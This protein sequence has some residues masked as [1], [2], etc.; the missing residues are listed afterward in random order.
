[1]NGASHAAN[2][3]QTPQQQ[4]GISVNSVT[5]RSPQAVRAAFESTG[6]VTKDEGSVPFPALVSDKLY[7]RGFDISPAYDPQAG[8]REHVLQTFALGRAGIG[9][10]FVFTGGHDLIERVLVSGQYGA[11]QV[12]QDL[13]FGSDF[14]CQPDHF[15]WL[16]VFQH[17]AVKPMPGVYA[18]LDSWFRHV[19]QGNAPRIDAAAVKTLES[20]RFGALS[21]CPLNEH[22]N[23]DSWRDLDRCHPDFTQVVKAAWASNRC[24][25]PNALRYKPAQGCPTDQVLQQLG[26]NPDPRRLRAYLYA[27]DSFSEFYTGYGYTASAYHR[28]IGREYWTDNSWVRNLP[29]VEL[30]RVQCDLPTAT[31]QSVPATAPPEPRSA[32]VE[33]Y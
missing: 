32:L 22:G 29:K 24:T 6:V 17:G 18:K 4:P 31:T 33:Q 16:V 28:P 2:S 14:Q 10:W 19:Y 15:Y 1:M 5:L 21:G 7:I 11:S 26:R 12:F 23:F 30:L 3:Q 8:D 25:N 27:V 20:Q 13:G 9:R